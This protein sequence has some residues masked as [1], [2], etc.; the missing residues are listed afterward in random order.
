MARCTCA[1]VVEVL[2]GAGNALEQCVATAPHPLQRLLS[3]A[4]IG[5]ARISSTERAGALKTFFDDDSARV[6]I[7]A[8]AALCSDGSEASADT[9][10]TRLLV[11]E[12]SGVMSALLGCFAGGQHADILKDRTLVTV[13]SR[14]QDRP[15]VEH[16]EP[17]I[18]VATIAR[19]RPSSAMKE[20]VN[21]LAG[22]AD[23]A[24]RDAAV[25][26]AF[27]ERSS[28]P[29]AVVV[30]APSPATLP[31]GA[32][33]RT[34]RGEILIAFDREVAPR[35]V[36]NFVDLAR[37]GALDNTPFHRVIADFVAQGGDPRG[38]GSGGPGYAI[39]NENHAGAFV[40]GAVGMAT[41]GTDTGGS[42]FFLTHSEQPHLD[43]R[44]TRFATVVDG[45][46]VMDALQREDLLFAV[47]LV[48]A[49][50]P[51][52]TPSPTTEAP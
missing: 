10:A 1:G 14:L 2:G 11:E 49:L 15:G 3:I 47:D 36:K 16:H 25:G 42:Q 40:R 35:T 51:R 19:A 18:T 20:L 52:S 21:T 6:R 30:A 45:L 8:A 37:K 9:A 22:H 48:T 46:P 33:L 39:P 41:A 17:L 43:G 24:V 28:G 5:L 26:I 4:T 12:D 31:A 13:A 27:G 29:R 44:Y 38:D 23:P 32:V 34:S 50:R 7:A